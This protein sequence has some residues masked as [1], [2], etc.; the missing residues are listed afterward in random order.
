MST[1]KRKV[2][3]FT[4]GCPVCDDT[5]KLV[6]ELACESCKVLI[7]DLSDTC[8]SGECLEKALNY[9]ITRVPSVVVDGKLAECC[10]AGAVSVD[11]LKAAGIGVSR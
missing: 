3:V 7:Y 9:G 6:K 5:V 2:E 4:A 11:G 1:E 10:K 8:E